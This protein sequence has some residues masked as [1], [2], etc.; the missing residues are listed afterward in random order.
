MKRL[1]M[2][3]PDELADAFD[4]LVARRGYENRSEAFRDLLR[5]DVGNAFL[6]RRPQGPCVATLSYLYAHEQRQL[7][8]RLVQMQ[9]EHHELT[10][11]ALH[12]HLD[13]DYCI[14]TVLLRGPA[15]RVQAFADEVLAQAGVSHGHLHLV[16]MQTSR[17]HGHT[18]LLPLAAA[19]SAR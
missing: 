11:S 16:P 5:Q 18:H 12:A 13:H 19:R 3:L 2:S 17:A 9:H 6:R 10:I 1:T 4:A 7:A 14:E 8:T 15:D